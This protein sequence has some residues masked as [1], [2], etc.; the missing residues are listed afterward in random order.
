MAKPEKRL[1]ALVVELNGSPGLERRAQIADE[2]L[3]ITRR[4]YDAVAESFERQRT[5]SLSEWDRRSWEMVLSEARRRVA[6]NRPIAIL[7]VGTAF[8]RDLEY[9]S[10]ISD[11]TILGIENSDSFLKRLL[12][13]EQRGEIPLGAFRAMDARDLSPLADE[14]FYVVRHNASLVH[15]PLIGRGFTIDLALAESWRVLAPEG[16]LFV[17]LKEGTGLKVQR[18]TEGL[19]DFAFQYYTSALA[20]AVI[21]RNGFRILDLGRRPSSRGGDVVWITVLAEKAANQERR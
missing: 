15:M 1:A 8:G 20:E 18:S 17:S 3:E 16:V 11:L 12:L 5:R 21:Q 6:Q 2:I 14:S 7:D 9:A 19:G 10:K 13:R 4:T